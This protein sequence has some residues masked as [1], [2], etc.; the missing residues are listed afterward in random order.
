MGKQ[1]FISRSE[2]KVAIIG[3]ED[4][5]TGMVL[6]GM[7]AVDGQ[8]KTNFFV[9]KAKTHPKQIEEKFLE[10][11]ARD[12]VA[13]LLLTQSCAELIRPA[14]DAYSTSGKVIPTILEIPSKDQPY[15]PKQDPIMQRVALFMPQ[16][17][18]QLGIQV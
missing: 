17:M 12:D 11:T 6:A 14:V 4:I 15:N 8:N 18:E 2:M 3:E 7:G 5:V 10:M 9:V 1:K 16:A 13:M